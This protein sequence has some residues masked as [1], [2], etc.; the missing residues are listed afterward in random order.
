M[1]SL[2]WRRD[3][4]TTRSQRPVTHPF[5]NLECSALMCT[6]GFCTK[7]PLGFCT[8]KHADIINAVK[9]LSNDTRLR[10]QS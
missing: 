7:C 2:T 10:L 3:L 6:V 5:W 1:I 4:V 9:L 8:K